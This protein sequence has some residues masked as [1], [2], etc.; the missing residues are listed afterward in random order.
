MVAKSPITR[1]FVYLGTVAFFAFF[2]LPIFWLVLSSFK[3][4]EAITA[5]RLIPLASDLTL[6]N[7]A[8]MFGRGDFLRYFANS[9]VI[10]LTV[11]IVTTLL[12]SL[13]AYGLSRFALRGKSIFLLSALLPQFFPYV[14]MLIP[15]YLLMFR[16]GLVGTHAGIILAHTSITLPFTFWMLTG[17]FNGIPKELDQAARI[18][19]CSRLGALFRVVLPIAVPGLVVAGFFAFTVSWSDYL[20]TSVLSQGVGTATLPIGLQTFLSSIQVRWGLITAGTVLV[21]TPTIILFAVVQRRLVSGL[22]S[23]AVKS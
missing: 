22:T 3:T 4:S 14:L 2:L 21:V 7:Y 13:G 18:D 12:S 1:I 5:S 23:G 20:F 8:E 9:L 19:G 15:F 11:S 10:A 16:F 6:A 17:Y